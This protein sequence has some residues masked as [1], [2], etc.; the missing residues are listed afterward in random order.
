VF[1]G[2]DEQSLEMSKLVER[3]DAVT[4]GCRTVVYFENSQRT[5]LSYKLERLECEPAAPATVQDHE[6]LQAMQTTE[7]ILG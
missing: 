2:L 6:I 4:S 7:T 1:F 5:D 3:V